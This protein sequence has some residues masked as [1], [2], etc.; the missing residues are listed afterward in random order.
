MNK[1]VP[2]YF[3]EHEAKPKELVPELLELENNDSLKLVGYP[4]EYMGTPK[5]LGIASNSDNFEAAYYIGASWIQENKIAAIVKP[6]ISD[7]DYL[8]MFSDALAVDSENES[9]YFSKCYGVEFDKPA[10]EVDSS[11]NIIT[12]LILIHYISVLT[13]LTKH[14]LKKGYVYREQNLQS[15]VKGH[16]LF[17]RHLQ[18]N[19]IPKREDNK[20]IEIKEYIKRANS[21]PWQLEQYSGNFILD[22]KKTNNIKILTEL[23]NTGISYFEDFFKQQYIDLPVFPEDTDEVINAFEESK[24]ILSEDS[25]TETR[26]HKVRILEL[27]EKIDDI[28]KSLKGN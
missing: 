28:I 23:N 9:D 16:L 20:S 3:T 7:I 27:I 2:V 22:L 8:K 12:P 6:K 18:S 25:K 15:K 26:L 13:K 1:V 5:H 11:F 4:D 17:Q 10:I 14:G 19:I 21:N 24:T